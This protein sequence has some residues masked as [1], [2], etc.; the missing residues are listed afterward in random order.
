MS[1]VDCSCHPHTGVSM[2]PSGLRQHNIDVSASGHI[3]IVNFSACQ[4]LARLGAM[5]TFQGLT[6]MFDVQ[7]LRTEPFELGAL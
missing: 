4:E 6:G 1:S 7:G 3:N 5:L 2:L